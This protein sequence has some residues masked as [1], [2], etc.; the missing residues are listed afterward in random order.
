MTQHS[1]SVGSKSAERAVA[2]AIGQE[3]ATRRPPTEPVPPRWLELAA[4]LDDK[5][6]DKRGP[7]PR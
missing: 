5:D 1:F 4:Q 6:D 3:M 2:D 7:K